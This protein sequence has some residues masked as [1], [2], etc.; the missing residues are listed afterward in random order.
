M[1][2]Q[3][4]LFSASFEPPKLPDR[5]LAG[6]CVRRTAVVTFA[7]GR[8]C[9]IESKYDDR[10]GTGSD[11]RQFFAV[12]FNRRPTGQAN[13]YQSGLMIAGRAAI[14]VF[15]SFAENQLL[16]AAFHVVGRW[17]RSA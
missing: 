13:H 4:L 12:Y 10:A 5:I 3:S 15:G 17:L 14:G 16:G 2:L 7:V 8:H 11:E 9:P 6:R 1:A